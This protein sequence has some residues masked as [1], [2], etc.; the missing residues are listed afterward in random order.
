MLETELVRVVT[1]R[2]SRYGKL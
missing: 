1:H 2:C